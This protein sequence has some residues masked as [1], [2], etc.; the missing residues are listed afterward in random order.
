MTCS[1]RYEF[2]W[3]CLQDWRQH[4]TDLCYVKIMSYFAVCAWLGIS[5]VSQLDS[6][7]G[8]EAITRIGEQLMLFKPL[9]AVH[10][11]VALVFA[12]LWLLMFV[13]I[14]LERKRDSE[15]IYILLIVIFVLQLLVPFCHAVLQ[16]ALCEVIFLIA[17]IPM[18]LATVVCL[19]AFIFY[20][21]SIGAS[22][23]IEYTSPHVSFLDNSILEFLYSK[24]SFNASKVL[25]NMPDTVLTYT[26]TWIT[27]SIFV[28]YKGCKY[29]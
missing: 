16:V 2:C 8:Y 18:I 25:N 7:S 23:V 22:Y 17:A 15:A 11:F 4:N 14:L 12:N 24:C 6:I 27:L 29:C 1:C 9:D 19:A 21:L 3:F 26:I 5:I 13:I 20:W 28:I 10:I